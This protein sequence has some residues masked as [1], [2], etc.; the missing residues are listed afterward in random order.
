MAVQ[1][2]AG[3][4]R[5][6]ARA[7]RRRPPMSEINVTPF[8][9]VMLV[10]LIVF[11]IAAPLLTVGVEVDLPDA[12]VGEISGTDEPIEISVQVDGSIYLMETSVELNELGPRLVAISQNNPEVRIFVRG[13]RGVAYGEVMAV[14]GALNEAGFNHM[15]LEAERPREAAE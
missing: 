10:L 15:A 4:G 14:M 1:F 13:D 3:S 6:S 11:M 9:D 2:T 5:R 8:V 7:R 12:N